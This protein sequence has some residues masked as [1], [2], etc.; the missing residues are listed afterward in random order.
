MDKNALQNWLKGKET[1]FACVLA[2]RA[3]LRV[4]PI[5]EIALHKDEK[6]RRRVI[7]LPSFRALAAAN[8]SG[9]LLGGAGEVRNFARCA[10]QEVKSAIDNVLDEAS[11]NVIHAREA[12]P[13][14]PEEVLQFERDA[15]DLSIAGDVVYAVVEAAQ[16]VVA[17]V[18]V[19]KEIGSPSTLIDVV[20]S[21]VQSAYTA[22][23]GIHGDTELPRDIDEYGASAEVSRQIT[24]F[25]DAVALDVEVLNA[26]VKSTNEPEEVVAELSEKPLWLDG[27]P[28]WASRRWTDFKDRLPEME[29][30][31][32][33][34]GWYE[35]RLAGQKLDAQLETDVLSIEIENWRQG[36]TH[37][38]AIIAFHHP[39]V[40][41]RYSV[42]LV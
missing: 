32:V 25:W 4:V 18:D 19:E 38:N 40:D 9:A 42:R 13:D 2:A 8:F 20:V 15:H 24:Q 22:I 7:I 1:A 6:E 14:F 41:S 37:V 31:G 11:M 33:W 26:G 29:G 10:G 27:T 28:E 35:E 36:P 30:W 3:A 39:T 23:D 12:I 16:S 5:M 17:K 34:I 21:V